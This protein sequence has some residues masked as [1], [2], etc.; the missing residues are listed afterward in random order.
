[1]ALRPGLQQAV[2]A[3]N[4]K[5]T[6]DEVRAAI[7]RALDQERDLVLNHGLNLD[8][9][10]EIARAELF[11]SV[12]RVV[13]WRSFNGTRMRQRSKRIGAGTSVTATRFSISAAFHVSCVPKTSSCARHT[14]DCKSVAPLVSRRSHPRMWLHNSQSAVRVPFAT[15]NVEPR[16]IGWPVHA[17]RWRTSGGMA[18]IIGTINDSGNRPIQVRETRAPGASDVAGTTRD[19]AIR[20]P[21]RE[22]SE[23]IRSCRFTIS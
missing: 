16:R 13:D 22:P 12:G 6:D 21:R 23:M 18:V 3:A 15:L 7:D 11:P 19:N 2:K 4:R 1:M 8:Q 20:G 17:W 10:R 9:A 5:M 14:C